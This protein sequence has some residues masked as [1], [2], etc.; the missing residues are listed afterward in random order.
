[1]T[2]FNVGTMGHNWALTNSNATD[3]KVLFGAQI[4]SGSNPIPINQTGSVVFRVTKA[5][6]YYYICQVPG[7]VQLGMWGNVVVSP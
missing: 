4:G 6:N 5:G 2:V 7:H 3:A 1:M